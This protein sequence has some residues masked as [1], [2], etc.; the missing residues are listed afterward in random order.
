MKKIFLILIVLMIWSLQ[1]EWISLQNSDSNTFN[2]EN[3]DRN[4]TELSFQLNGYEIETITKAGEKYLQISHPG[5]GDLLQIGKPDLPVFT[6]LVAISGTGTPQ[7][8]YQVLNNSILSD[9][10][11]FPRQELRLESEPARDEFKRDEQYYTSGSIFPEASAFLGEPAIMRDIRLVP[12]TVCP[13]TWDPVSRE[14]TIV[15]EFTLQVSMTSEPGIN[16]LNDD[17]YISRAFEL[18][19]KGNI[20][21]YE[22]SETRDEFQQPSILFIHTNN[23]QVTSALSYL[24][25]WKHER[26]YEVHTASTTQAGTSNIAIKNYIQSAYNNWENPPEYVVLVGDAGGSYNIPT[27]IDTWSSYN[28]EGDQ[29]YSQLAGEDVLADIIVGRMPFENITELQT[30]IAKSINYEKQPYVTNPGWMETITLV[31]DSSSSGPSTIST[32]RY[33]QEVTLAYNPDFSYNEIFSGSYSS[34]MSSALNGGTL[35][36]CYRGF[37]GM[38]GFNIISITSLNNGWMLP[39]VTI[40]TCGTGGFLETCRSE[41]FARAGSITNP[42]GAIASVGTATTGTHTCFNN[43]V[44]AGMYEGIFNLDIFSPGGALVNGKYNLYMNYPQNPS[45]YVNMFSHWNNLMGDPSVSLY[46]GIPQAINVEYPL[47]VGLGALNIPVTVTD[48]QGTGIENAW[49]TILK[50]GDEIFAT[51]YTN[52]AG[53]IW[54]PIPEAESGDVIITVTAHDYLSFQDEFTIAAQNVQLNPRDYDIDDDNFGSS[55]GNGNSIINNGETIELDILVNNSGS[56]AASGV[57][58]IINCP[59]PWITITTPEVSY[60]DINAGEELAPLSSFILNIDPAV[61]G[62]SVF[63]LEVTISSGT[64]EFNGILDLTVAAPLLSFNS[65]T[66][67][68]ISGII[69]PGETAGITVEIEN[70]GDIATGS[71]TALL[72]SNDSFI[73]ID[74]ANGSYNNI[75]PGNSAVNLGNFFEITLSSF[76]IPGTLIPF[77]MTLSNSEGFVQ[78][79]LFNLEVGIVT[80]NDPLGPDAYGYLAYDD[81]DDG[82]LACPTYNWIE[83]NPFLGGNGTQVG[84]STGGDDCDIEDVS[85]PDSFTFNYYGEQYTMFTVGTAGWIAPGGTQIRSFMNWHVPEAHGPSPMIAAFWDDIHN[86]YLGHVY[87]YY[88]PGMHYYVIEWDHFQNEYNNAEETFQIILYDANYY[89]TSTMDSKIKIQYKVFNNVNQGSYRA[90]HG[91][92]CTVGLEDHTGMIGLEYTFDNSY[93]TAARTITDESAILFTTMPIPPD[94]PILTMSNI[95]LDDENGNGAADYG[96]NIYFDLLISNVGS[97]IAHNVS[98]NLS[99]I[100]TWIDLI[101]DSSAYPDIEAG[102]IESNN[103]AFYLTVDSEVPDGHLASI[104]VII[105]SNES[106]WELITEIELNAPLVSYYNYLVNDGIDNILDAGETADVLISFANTGGAPVYDSQF[107][108]STNDA[109]LD[110]NNDTYGPGNIN[111]ES[112]IMGI[113]GFTASSGSTMSHSCTVH[114]VLNAGQD[115]SVSGDFIFVISQVPVLINEDFSGTFPPDGWYI[116]GQNWESGSSNNAGGSAPEAKFIW[117]PSVNGDQ[118]LICGPFSTSG[119]SEIDLSFCQN[120]NH[121]SGI[122]TLALETS[123]NGNNW[124]QTATWPP[125]NQSATISNVNIYNSDVGSPTFYFAFTFSGNSSNINYWY[126]DNV[127]IDEPSL[128]LLGYIQGI[129]SIGGTG[130]MQD[131]MIEVDDQIAQPNSLGEYTLILEPGTYDLTA[132]LPGYED[133]IVTDIQIIQTQTTNQNIMLGFI[134]SPDGLI[135]VA[136]EDGVLLNWELSSQEISHDIRDIEYYNIYANFNG[137]GYQLAGTSAEM[138]FLHTPYLPGNYHYYVTA[139]YTESGETLPSN[140]ASSWYD[141][142]VYFGDINESTVVDAYDTALL[143]QYFVGLDPL[144]VIDPVPW[145]NWRLYLGDVDDNGNMEAFDASLILQYIV[146]IIDR[147]PCEPAPVVSRKINNNLNKNSSLD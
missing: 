115:Y 128:L 46:T 2:C 135:S 85:F 116:D 55:I 16:E 27:W 103:Q 12:V 47:I 17:N 129:V 80:G 87:T 4:N 22:V 137:D 90:D 63:Q 113:F 146:G 24:T 140:E 98:V 25:T 14:L 111:S 114:W 1:A 65:Y 126:I 73:E 86:G 66:L 110:I 83:I 96:E 45:N 43:C 38:S 13:F 11:I 81:Q 120:V 145:E 139:Y 19:Y 44:T 64:Q 71:L 8:C 142:E 56:Q 144:P 72:S 78:T 76:A 82:Y 37:I 23:T 20:I 54:L 77:L 124:Q 130:N 99:T 39:F 105:S 127:E 40:L 92:Y 30:M 79:I 57:T 49:V 21:N 18:F 104:N 26:G 5:E 106:A 58:G 131:V 121:Y 133:F 34:Q 48:A 29:P 7:L 70:L 141:G 69:N 84:I 102:T 119:S 50:G 3:S 94:G 75:L 123:S 53:D 31:G 108:L 132:T 138:C 134:P 88:D 61:I 100:D 74:D 97:E 147:F 36:F 15:S 42:K 118:R 93:P 32:C 95:E 10:M 117:S 125:Q 60:P 33:V 41:V 122:Y 9:V 112:I 109:Y 89:P 107:T 143:L 6:T 67:S 28:G 51:G 91:Q 62:G 68:G 136:S 35:Y 101:D 52:A 59:E